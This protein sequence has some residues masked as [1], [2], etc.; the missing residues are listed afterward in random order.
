VG[1]AE[2]LGLLPNVQTA[3]SG[4]S[5]GFTPLTEVLDNNPSQAFQESRQAGNV[6]GFGLPLVLEGGGV[7]KPPA[8]SPEL[9]PVGPG[10][11]FPVENPAPLV[12]A[13]ETR[14][15]ETRVENN[16]G[17]QGPLQ[18]QS[19]DPNNQQGEGGDPL[20]TNSTA[21][22]K[23][24]AFGAGDLTKPSLDPSPTNL[25]GGRPKTSNPN[26]IPENI[27]ADVRENESPITLAQNGYS[28]VH[29]PTADD[30]AKIGFQMAGAKNPDYIIEGKVFD[31]LA[32]S[33]SNARN[34][35]SRIIEKI[36]AK[37]TERVIL[38]LDDSEVSLDK[39]REQLTNFPING[40]KELII[41]KNGE[42]VPFSL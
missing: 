25:P 15:L 27:R 22:N 4:S 12:R 26:D 35:A 38:N 29:N 7:G 20:K 8:S 37:Q 34:I 3:D 31:N 17:N 13:P 39:L 40:L 23:Q 33:T 11:R 9:V 18:S 41:V 21:E 10:V 2:G 32:P 5:S 36:D 6:I 28:V 30:L 1:L 16:Q 24:G 42:V 19:T 14:L